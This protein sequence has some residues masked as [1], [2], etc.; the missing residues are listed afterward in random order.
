MAMLDAE[1]DRKLRVLGVP[2]MVVAYQEQTKSMD[3]VNQPFEKRLAELVDAAYQ[4]KY[5]E[6]VEHL[7]KAAHLR[8]PTA[9][10]TQILYDD[11]RPFSRELVDEL[12]TCH[13]VEQHTSLIIQGY[14]SSGKTYLSCAFAKEACKKHYKTAYI[15]MSD[16]LSAD[17]EARISGI[18]E[19]KRLLRKY[20]QYQVLVI[21]EWLTTGVDEDEVRFLYELAE[22]RFDSTSTIF[23]TLHDKAEWL[24]RT[25]SGQF[26]STGIR[27][28]WAPSGRQP[29]EGGTEERKQRF[30][31][32]K[33]CSVHTTEHASLF[34][35]T[36]Q[37][38]GMLWAKRDKHRR[39]MQAAVTVTVILH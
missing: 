31:S 10:V 37:H 9:D 5:N 24:E 32:R 21:D 28:L 39:A 26:S 14:P 29:T 11:K 33:A 4:A 8:I 34:R 7:L 35:N 36:Q 27:H 17:E 12:A 18:R 13:F 19:E 22:R 25:T 15:R 6:K 30:N 20:S 23:A 38:S 16:L 1:T 3:R 2:E